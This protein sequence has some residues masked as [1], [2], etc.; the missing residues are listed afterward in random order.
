[1]GGNHNYP[2]SSYDSAVFLLGLFC[3][4][5]AVVVYRVFQLPKRRPELWE[6]WY[7]IQGRVRSCLRLGIRKSANQEMLDEQ[8]AESEG[9]NRIQKL[10][11]S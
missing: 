11:S 4:L 2:S 8:V 5:M 10:P 6:D 9:E 3:V 7:I 1:M